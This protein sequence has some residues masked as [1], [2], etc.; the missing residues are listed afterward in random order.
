MDDTRARPDRPTADWRRHRAEEA[1][2]LAAGTLDP[3]EAY[4]AEL[5]PDSML[6]AT[7]LVLA[8]FEEE[9]AAWGAAPADTLVLGAVERAVLALNAVNEEHDGAAYETDERERLCAY[10][11]E[12]LITAGVEV[13]AL[14]A[15]QGLG[16][17]EI[18]DAWRDW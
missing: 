3:T 8:A 9:A 10:I 6:A 14:A 1:A 15:R 7:D 16:R 12:V 2:E 5:F 11:D 4:L 17:Y 13:G 18:T